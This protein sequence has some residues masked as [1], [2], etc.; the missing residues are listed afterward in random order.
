MCYD[1]DGGYEMLQCQSCKYREDCELEVNEDYCDH[2]ADAFDA[3]VYGD[4]DQYGCED[5][6]GGDSLRQ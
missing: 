2:F 6:E 3:E 1:A 4:G 5:V